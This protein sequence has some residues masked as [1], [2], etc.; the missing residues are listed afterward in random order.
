MR[1]LFLILLTQLIVTVVVVNAAVQPQLAF[2]GGSPGP[3]PGL[4]PTQTKV[5]RR[6]RGLKASGLIAAKW[7]SSRNRQLLAGCPKCRRL[8]RGKERIGRRIA[9]YSINRKSARVSAQQRR[10]AEIFVCDD[11]LFDVFAGI[12]IVQLGMK[13]ALISARFDALVD[14]HFKFLK[15]SLGRL[16]IRREEYGTQAEIV[17]RFGNNKN[18]FPEWPPPK[19]I[20]GFKSISISH[21]DPKAMEFLHCSRRLFDVDIAFQ[22]IGFGKDRG[23]AFREIWPL[24]ANNIAKTYLTGDLLSRYRRLIASTVLCDCANLRSI[25]SFNIYPEN[26]ADDAAGASNG[27][28]LSKWLHT[29]WKDGRPKLLTMAQQEPKS[30]EALKKAFINATSPPFELFNGLTRER[31]TLRRVRLA[32]KFDMW[33]LERGP[34]KRDEQRWTEWAQ[35]ETVDLDFWKENNVVY[36]NFDEQREIGPRRGFRCCC[37]ALPAKK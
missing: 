15:R 28:A 34:D 32:G 24:F 12:G 19:G 6:R 9:K 5:I 30:V 13:M 22:C 36:V 27:Q 20:N 11:V 7:L 29:P 26:P 16:W 37:I 1:F 25:H 21:I 10:P 17:P 14:S 4:P 3:S 35:Q 23:K 31:M 33:L 8:P 2:L 18:P